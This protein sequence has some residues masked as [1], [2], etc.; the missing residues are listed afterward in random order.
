MPSVDTGFERGQLLDEWR[1]RGEHEELATL[2][3]LKT[4]RS[5]RSGSDGRSGP[6]RILLLPGCLIT[7]VALGAAVIA[8]GFALYAYTSTPLPT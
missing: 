1:R 7:L 2:A 6:R 5:T 8:L 4:I 3:Q